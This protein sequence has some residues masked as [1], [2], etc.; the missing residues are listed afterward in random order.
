MSEFGYVPVISPPT[1]QAPRRSDVGKWD[2]RVHVRM[3]LPRPSDQL[4][5][6]YI[7]VEV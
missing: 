3:L 1:P 6:V 2:K 5:E 4:T 7:S